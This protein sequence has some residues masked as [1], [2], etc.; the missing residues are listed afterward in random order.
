[1]SKVGAASMT[2]NTDHHQT[3]RT[4]LVFEQ[5]GIGNVS[6]GFFRDIFMDDTFAMPQETVPV[7]PV[8]TASTWPG[9]LHVCQL[10]RQTDAYGMPYC[11]CIF[12]AS[13]MFL[14][15]RYWLHLCRMSCDRYSFQ[16]ARVC[17]VR[18]ALVLF[19][20]IGQALQP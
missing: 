18:T 2:N 10:P 16:L 12:T 6:Y 15:L 20:Q 8:A 13:Y 19:K 17:H 14:E 7:V 11:K 5:E 4:S 1:M 3:T 9:K